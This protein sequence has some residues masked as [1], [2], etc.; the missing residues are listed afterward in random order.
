LYLPDDSRGYYGFGS[1]ARP[2]RLSAPSSSTDTTTW[3]LYRINLF[4]DSAKILRGHSYGVKVLQELKSSKFRAYELA[5]LASDWLI[6]W[7][8][9]LLYL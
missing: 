8:P 7:G 9:A 2:R 1:V 6:I 5:V 4:S 3:S